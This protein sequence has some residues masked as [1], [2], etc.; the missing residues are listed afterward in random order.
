M[1]EHKK[2]LGIDYG[3]KRVGIA[4]SDETLIFSFAL[5][6]IENKGDQDL[7]EEIKKIISK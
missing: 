1:E 5:K 4:I 2:I 6:T 3:E 7:V